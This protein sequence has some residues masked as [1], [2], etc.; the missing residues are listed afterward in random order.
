VPVE[1]ISTI[2]PKNAGSFPVV[3]DVNILG[4]W[5]IVATLT[6]R[7]LIPSLRR[8]EGM[9]VY[10][11]ANGLVYKLTGGIANTN[12][13]SWLNLSAISA[14][15][16]DVNNPHVTTLE[17]ARVAG[18]TLAGD[19]NMG[20]HGVENIGIGSNDQAAAQRRWVLDR[21]AGGYAPSLSP[22]NRGMQATVTLADNSLACITPILA[23][24]PVNAWLVVM[25][26]GVGYPIGNGT[27]ASVPCYFSHDGGLTA[28]ATG[29]IVTG[30]LLYWNGSVAG[31]QL[32]VT[33]RID[34]IF[35]A[36]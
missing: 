24:P 31:F 33:D 16:V 32:G 4:G 20:A 14:H 30:D 18:A 13:V 1:V 29:A 35:E 7:D 28:R 12:W 21:L 23:A 27:K 34:F 2:I 11:V 19:I 25:V 10:V 9:P 17:Q 3:E 15:L 6:D 26:N 5:H 36:L 8:K 22:L